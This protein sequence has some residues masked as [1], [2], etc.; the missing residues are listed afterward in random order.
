M[1]YFGIHNEI[2][3]ISFN[4]SIKLF[5]QSVIVLNFF[6]KKIICSC[7]KKKKNCRDESEEEAEE[8]NVQWQAKVGIETKIRPQGLTLLLMPLC[9]HRRDYHECP[10]IEA[11][12]S[13]KSQTQIFIPNQW[14]EAYD[15]CGWIK[16]NLEENEEQGNP[17]RTPA[18]STNLGPGDLSYTKP[19]TRQDKAADMRSPIHLQQRI[20]RSWLNQ[21]R[22]T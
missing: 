3:P 16:E 12:S 11:I 1:K 7:L 4:W 22:F 9:Y 20:A 18:V 2:I 6:F 5:F 15:L 13:W 14:T 10:L 8:K 19:P 17:I 21:R